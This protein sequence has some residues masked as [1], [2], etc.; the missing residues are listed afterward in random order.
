LKNKTIVTIRVY[1]QNASLVGVILNNRVLEAGA[2][3]FSLNAG[4][5]RSGVYICVIEIDGIPYSRKFLKR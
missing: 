2:H 3:S 1:T 5:L 4:N